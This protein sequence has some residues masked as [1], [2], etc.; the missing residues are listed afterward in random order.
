L[1]PAARR[2]WLFADQ[3]G[4]HFLDAPDQPV[5]LIVSK[6]AFRRRRYHRQKAHLILS[7]LRHRAAELGD[8]A[9]LIEAETYGEALDRLGE[10][11]EICD[12]TSFAARR[13]VASRPDVEVIAERGFVTSP[14]DFQAWAEGRGARR[15]LMEDFYR[16]ARR[17]LGILMDGDEP[18]GG[19]WNYDHDNRKPPPRSNALPV[20]PPWTPEEDDIDAAVRRDLDGWD[21]AFAGADGP[22]RFAAT[23]EEAGTALDRFIADRLKDFGP[24]EDAMLAEDPAMAHSLLS[25]AI[26]LGLLDPLE[27]VRA[28]EAAYRSG[29]TPLASAEGFVRQIM[30]WRDYVWHLYWHFGPEYRA[31][32]GLNAH[33]QVPD[34]LWELDADGI[35]AACVRHAV[36]GVRDR[37]WV[38]HIQRLMVLGN[39]A[40]QQGIDPDSLTT[41]FHVSFVDGYEWVMVPN[42]IGMSQH[43]DGGRMATKPYA[44]GGAYIHRMSDYCGDCAYDP[45]RRVGE[46]ACPMTAGYWAWM[47]RNRTRLERNGRMQQ[48]V[49]GLDRLG[50]IDEVVAEHRRRGTS[51]P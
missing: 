50:D 48:A 4:P 30:G 43:A 18:V 2:R 19:A 28:A 33:Q 37:G 5:L 38:H 12:P 46:R 25:P 24:W 41:W 45:K 23:V 32:N 39:W 8:A 6:A 7:A 16:A 49:R 9:I 35:E 42:V 47:H 34:W 31:A 20:A 11:V 40:L 27:V 17:R 21:V 29:V 51:A 3:L 10:P 26:N 22:R 15:L 44:A 14:A 36:A 13:F 1:T